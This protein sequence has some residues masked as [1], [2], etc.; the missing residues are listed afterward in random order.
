MYAYAKRY[1]ANDVWLIYP[2]SYELEHQSLN[3]K[4]YKTIHDYPDQN[5]SIQIDTNV[6]IHLYFLDLSA[7]SLKKQ[8]DG[9]ENIKKQLIELLK[10]SI[11]E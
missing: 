1:K 8:R 5:K 4:E 10:K 2:Y 7:L 11:A 9:L 6:T 3:G